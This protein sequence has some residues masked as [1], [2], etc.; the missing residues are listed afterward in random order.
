MTGSMRMDKDCRMFAA[1]REDQIKHAA[2][3]VFMAA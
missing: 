1:I 3:E 2:N